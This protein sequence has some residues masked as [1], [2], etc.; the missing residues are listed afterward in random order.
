MNV[1]PRNLTLLVNWLKRFLKLSSLKAR[2]TSSK[3]N[4]LEAIVHQTLMGRMTT[5][6]THSPSGNQSSQSF[7]RKTPYNN[8]Q[9]FPLPRVASPGKRGPKACIRTEVQQATLASSQQ[10]LHA[11]ETKVSLPHTHSLSPCSFVYL[12][13]EN[14]SRAGRLKFFFSRTWNS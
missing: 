11:R 9:P 6:L 13:L 10:K 12:N 7:N 8:N 5:P 2:K 3:R 14:I 1:K 4:L